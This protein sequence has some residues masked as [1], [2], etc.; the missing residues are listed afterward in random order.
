VRLLV[1]GASGFIGRNLVLATPRDWHVVATYHDAQDFPDFLAARGLAHVTPVR[2]DLA[3]AAPAEI[4]GC[5][6]PEH[7]AAVF[8]AANGDPARSVHAPRFDLASNTLSLVAVLEAVRVD[9]LVYFSSGAVYDGVRGDVRPDVAVRPRLPYAISKLASEHYVRSFTHAG[10]VR[11][12]VNVRFFGA[13]GPHE[14]ERK[15]YMRLVRAF[16]L[17]G[18]REFTVR[19]DGRNLID[20]MYVDD[21]TRAIRM[22][23]DDRAA[24][25]CDT[26]DLASGAPLSL[27]ALV[28]AA[29]ATF[30]IEPR[31]VFEG[32]VPEYIEFRSVDPTMHERY[33]FRPEVPLAEGLRRLAAHLGGA[34]G[35]RPPAVSG[36]GHSP[37]A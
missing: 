7:D 18:H 13:F 19:G 10:R 24:Q 6:G 21:T 12:A 27:E 9:R 23:L 3:G 14:P 28:R 36:L 16:A 20:A 2:I 25:G 1:T 32:A 15:V 33:A 29:A 22:L 5:L 31:I 30:G 34:A 4:A 11:S 17:E 37:G 26:L 35:N 8:L